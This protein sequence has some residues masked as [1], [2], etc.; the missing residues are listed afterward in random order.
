LSAPSYTPQL[1]PLSVGEILDAG[2]RLFR[3][4]F[5]TLVLCVLVPIVPLY[6]L[7]TLIVGSTD[8]NAFDVNAPTSSGGRAAVGQL[9]DRLLAEHRRST[10]ALSV[11]PRRPVA[12]NRRRS[13]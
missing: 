5:G 10:P 7:G 2:F 3:H 11:V 9:L 8:P 1:R 6:V 4:R 12:G 13:A